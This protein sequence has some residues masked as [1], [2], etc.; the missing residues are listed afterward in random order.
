MTFTTMVRL[1]L[2]TLHDITDFGFMAWL[3]DYKDIKPVKEEV[4]KKGKLKAYY[5]MTLEQWQ[6]LRR[7]YQ[8]TEFFRFV[9][10]MGAKRNLTY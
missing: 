2:S 3:E 8:D 7:E 4:I 9:F 6:S 1:F 10:K 5:E